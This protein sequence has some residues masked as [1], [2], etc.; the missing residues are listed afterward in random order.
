MNELEARKR[1]LVAES[2]LYRQMLRLEVQNLQLYGLQLRQKFAGFRK[3][4]PAVVLAAALAGSLFGRKRGSSLRRTAMAILSWQL[5]NR[6]VPFLAGLFSQTRTAGAD[7]A[8]STQ[9]PPRART[10]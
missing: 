3:P 6:L 7:G 2:E 10:P 9:P 1:A 8:A 4:G 5:S